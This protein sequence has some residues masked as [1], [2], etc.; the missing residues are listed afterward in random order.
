MSELRKI[1]TPPHLANMVEFRLL[2][3]V[4][5]S[6]MSDFMDEVEARND[7]LLI[8]TATEYGIARRE[9]I[10]NIMPN[11]DDSLDVRRTRVLLKWYEKSPYTPIVL[12]RKLAYLC[13]GGTYELS[14]DADN[15]IMHL[16]IANVDY[17]VCRTIFETIDDMI[18]LNVIIDAK[19]IKIDTINGNEYVAAAVMSR[20]KSSIVNHSTKETNIQGAALSGSALFTS[21]KTIILCS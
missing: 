15:M 13:E 19:R 4:S 8:M 20:A 3:A 5:D 10:L 7:D 11:E 12:N 1:E 21:P 17:E 18:M 6:Q 16:S 2:D 14:Y 9:K